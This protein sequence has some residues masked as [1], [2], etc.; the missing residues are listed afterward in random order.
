MVKAASEMT[1]EYLS[2]LEEIRQLG[3]RYVN[4][5]DDGF[6]AGPLADLFTADGIWQGPEGFGPYKGREALVGFF[7]M[8]GGLVLFTLH[9]AINAEVEVNGDSATGRWSQISVNT[10]KGEDAPQDSWSFLLYNNE[11]AR[12]DGRWKFK[13]MTVTTRAGGAHDAGW[14]E[15]VTSN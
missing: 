12:V 10:F 13:H 6:D 4:L 11:Y 5:C 3:H 9:A 15:S 8:F 2:D 7:T 14:A 1:H